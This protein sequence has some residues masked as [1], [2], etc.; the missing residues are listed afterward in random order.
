M[1]EIVCRHRYQVR[2]FSTGTSSFGPVQFWSTYRGKTNTGFREFLDPEYSW[3]L[4]KGERHHIDHVFTA[5]DR[6]PINYPWPAVTCR[7]R[8]SREDS[9]V[10]VRITMD[11]DVKGVPELTEVLDLSNPILKAIELCA[12]IVISEPR[13]R[14]HEFPLKMDQNQ[15]DV[16]AIRHFAKVKDRWVEL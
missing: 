12:G 15:I 5:E 2:C 13:S 1:A 6:T 11:E 16:R 8:K 3:D 9:Q 4:Y 7:R 10:V 14:A